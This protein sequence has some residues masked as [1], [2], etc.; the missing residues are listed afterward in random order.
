MATKKK[1]TKKPKKKDPPRKPKKQ[2]K[3]AKSAA[4]LALK[5]APKKKA[6]K[7]RPRG[8]A[9]SAGLAGFQRK[10]LGS[11]TGGQ[12]RDTQGIS[13][14]PDIDSGSVAEPTEQRHTFA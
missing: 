4:K 10:G 11:F 5:R 7:K 1:P 2:V 14:R 12:G 13:R 6:A 3:K 9:D 8:K